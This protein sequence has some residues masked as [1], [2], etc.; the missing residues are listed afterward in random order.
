MPSPSSQAARRWVIGGRI[1]GVGFRPFVCTLANELGIGGSVRNQGGQVEI[2]AHGDQRLTALFLRRVMAEHPPIARPELVSDDIFVP[3]DSP[4]FCILPSR[5]GAS[6]VLLPDQP[7]C[8]TCLAE[9]ADPESR[10]FRYPFIAC[11]QCGPRYTII[12][13]MPFDRATTGM[14][15]FPLCAPCREEYARPA[16][17]RFHAQIM[18]CAACGPRLFYRD[19]RHAGG[20]N[21]AALARTVAAL[22]EGAIVAVKGIGGYHLLCDAGSTVAVHRLRA[23]KHRPA[24]PL[25]VLFPRAGTDGLDILRR[26]C[27]PT[28][29]EARGLRA[30]E[31]PIVLVARRDDCSLS[32]ALA[33]GLRELGA[34]LP[35]APLHDLIAGDFGRPLVATSGNVGGEPVLTEQADAEHR[36][37]AI[38][39]AFLHHDRP[40]L[41]PADDGV[42]RVIAAQP[43][44]LRL[45]RGSAPLALALP[46]ALPR[47]MLALGGQ[48]KV[49]LALG[50][51]D[52]AV[53]SPHLGVLDSPRGMELLE[54]TAA[55][56]QRLHGVRAATLI[57]DAHGGY[58]GTRW[59]LAQ[60]DVTV[61]RLP[62]HYAHAAAVAGEFP[63]EP[64]WLCF[65]W[66]GVG[67]GADGTLW[68]GEALLG[69]P[70]AWVRAATFRPF[71]PPGGEAAAREPWRSAAAL[72]WELGL[73]WQPA[74]LDVALARAAWRQRLNCPATSSV[75]RLFDAAAAFLLLVQHASYEGEGPMA[76]EAIAAG[77]WDDAVALPLACRADG[78]LEADWATL[79]PLLR[80]AALSP[81]R[82]AAAFHA[83]MA[84]AL[85]D[86]AVAVRAAHGAFAVGLGGGVFQNRRL[87][88]MAL[89]ALADSGF[90]AYLP[91]A[92]PCN[93]AGLSFGQLIEAAALAGNG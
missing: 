19:E 23:R 2:V 48:T 58:A 87:S 93:D 15:G 17:R 66:D 14:A 20:G 34:L 36:L 13:D 41:H 25:A 70:G 68:G 52:R 51:G 40:I 6:A 88:E 4:G 81:A 83:S 24:K 28:A 59:A 85:V 78:V 29:A 8:E 90:R 72:A 64:R 71:A 7:V 61:L 50:F 60:P 35:Y 84:R 22:R 82:R 53:I 69:C 86:Q 9:M 44:R 21:E 42:V 38:A 56:L 91:V 77:G 57:C 73:D 75:G 45:G 5:A 26:H 37:G 79:V 39:D 32:P 3:P 31:R 12:A 27:T 47:P 89:S 16:D 49:T 62:H 46:R 74:G 55:T 63:A 76:L 1:Q 10:R 65:A 92:V 80:D 11:T 30:P 54:A 43:R 18:G 67:L 33:P